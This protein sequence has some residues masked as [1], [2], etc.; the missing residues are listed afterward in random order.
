[1]SVAIKRVTNS[2]MDFAETSHRYMHIQSEDDYN[3]ALEIVEQ[4]MLT[5]DNSGN[6]PLNDL[7]DIIS[8]SIEVYENQQPDIKSFLEKSNALANDLSTLRLL[9][10]QHGLG[11]NDFKNEI[12][13]KSYVSMIL[14]QERNLNKSHIKKLSERFN[15]SPE[16]FF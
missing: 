3:E 6:D 11:V 14:N 2:F 12:G 4:I 13:S 1:M 7:L 8:N 9:M 5:M 10:E 15:I 16:L